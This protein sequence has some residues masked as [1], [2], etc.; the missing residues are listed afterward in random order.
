[1][2]K[3]FLFAAAAMVSLS[4][5]VQTEEVYTGSVSEMGFKSAV[6]RAVIN[7]TSD[8]VLPIAVSSVLDNTEDATEN[9]VPYF[10]GAKFVYDEGTELWRGE[11]ARYWPNSGHM[12]FLGFCPYPTTATLV[13]NYDAST[14]KIQNVVASGI[15]N[16]I[17]NQHDILYSD[18]LSVDAP[19][20]AAQPLLFHHAQAQL[21]VTFKKTDSQ[22]VVVLNSVLLEG[23]FLSGNLTITPVEGGQSV[24]EWTT[25]GEAFTKNRFFNKDL[26]VSGVEVSELG[27]TLTATE[28]YSPL[29]LMVVPGAQKKMLITYTVDGHQQV[30]ELDLTNNGEKWEMGHK[31]TYN[32]TINVNEIIFD[33]TVE[34]WIPVDGGNITI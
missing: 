14:G 23:V 20:T 16:N 26:T 9:Y 17:L 5:C 27:A 25:P 22:A 7:S 6:T 30:Y 31:Y 10:S 21:N 4:S 33:C 34:N 32:F 3:I 28:A 29:P 12:Y 1:M 13:T 15:D 11:P 18:L 2:K 8:L 19:Q 24:A